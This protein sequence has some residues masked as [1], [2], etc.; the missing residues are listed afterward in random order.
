MCWRRVLAAANLSSSGSRTTRAEEDMT[1]LTSAEVERHRHDGFL[2]PF[3]ALGE[4]ERMTC[5][6]GLERYERWLGTTVP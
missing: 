1:A 5:L 4:A 6:A 3:P 2:F